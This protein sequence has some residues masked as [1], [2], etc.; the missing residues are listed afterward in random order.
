MPQWWLYLGPLYAVYKALDD[1]YWENH[2]QR[3]A[4]LMEQLARERMQ[5]EQ[6]RRRRPWLRAIL[7]GVL[8]W[9]AACMLMTMFR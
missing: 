6:A 2:P 7:V 3:R 5:R 1:R 8:L 4:K 9:I